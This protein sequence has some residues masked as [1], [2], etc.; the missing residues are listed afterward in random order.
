MF[1]LRFI[2]K[3]TISDEKNAVDC[4]FGTTF[5][6]NLKVSQLNHTLTINAGTKAKVVI[7]MSFSLFIFIL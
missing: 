1:E 3:M 4:N 7:N 2:I 5:K 6:L